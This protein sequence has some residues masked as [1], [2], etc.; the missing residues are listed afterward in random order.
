MNQLY[1][2]PRPFLYR[3]RYA[4]L[5]SFAATWAISSAISATYSVIAHAYTRLNYRLAFSCTQAAVTVCGTH[6]TYFVARAF[7]TVH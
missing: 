2:D 7:L 6:A 5:L 4:S 1:A 3:H